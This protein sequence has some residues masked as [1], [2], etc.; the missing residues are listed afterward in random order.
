MNTGHHVAHTRTPIARWYGMPGAVTEDNKTGEWEFLLGEGR[1]A[2]VWV[3]L[4][5]GGNTLDTLARKSDG[6]QASLKFRIMSRGS[7]NH[8]HPSPFP[9]G[10]SM[11]SPRS[12]RV[13]CC[14]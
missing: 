14:P 6:N 7:S 1:G 8:N 10:C 4:P 11:R 2:I 3:N 12:S 9:R 13:N 5:F